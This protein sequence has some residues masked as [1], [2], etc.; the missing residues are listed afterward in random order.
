MKPGETEADALRRYATLSATADLASRV[1]VVHAKP[2]EAF[3]ELWVDGQHRAY[4]ANAG[5][6]IV[7]AAAA[8]GMSAAQLND[9]HEGLQG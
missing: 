1:R 6:A 3:C 4:C 2:Y 8:L 7:L 9:I 5:T